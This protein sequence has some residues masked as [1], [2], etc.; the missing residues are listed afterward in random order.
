MTCGNS[1][2]VL[3]M[4]TDAEWLKEGWGAPDSIMSVVLCLP[5]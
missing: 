4:A 3:H 1:G 2:N 5:T